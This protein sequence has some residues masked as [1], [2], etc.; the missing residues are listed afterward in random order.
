MCVCLFLGQ[1]HD[2]AQRYRQS[3]NLD[4]ALKYADPS[5]HPRFRAECVLAKARISLLAGTPIPTEELQESLDLFQKMSNA[6]FE[7]FR[8][9]AESALILGKGQSSVDMLK[10]AHT[11]YLKAQHVCGQIQSISYQLQCDGFTMNI[12]AQEKIIETLRK[13][14]ALVVSL[15]KSSTARSQLDKANIET[16]HRF[17]GLVTDQGKM[18]M[19][20]HEGP[21]MLTLNNLTQ[22]LKIRT[23]DDAFEEKDANMAIRDSLMT[24]LLE[25]T[26]HLKRSLLQDLE[27]YQLCRDFVRGRS[28]PRQAGVSQDTGACSARHQPHDHDSY[29]ML[30]SILGQ[31]ISVNNLDTE[32]LQG[33]KDVVI[34]EYVEGKMKYQKGMDELKYTNLLLDELFPKY[35]HPRVMTHSVKFTHELIRLVSGHQ[36]IMFSMKQRSRKLQEEMQS[37]DDGLAATENLLK[38][39]W[40]EMI[41]NGTPDN[42]L[43]CIYDAERVYGKALTTSRQKPSNL[44][45]FKAHGPSGTNHLCFFRK[46]ISAFQLLYKNGDLMVAFGDLM[47]FWDFLARRPLMPLLPTLASCL[48][49]LEVQTVLAAGIY[50]R[51]SLEPTPVLLPASYLAAVNFWDSIFKAKFSTEHHSMYYVIQQYKPGLLWK[52]QFEGRLRKL[53]KIFC[54]KAFRSFNIMGDS[55]TQEAL[56]TGE[57]ERTLILSLVL[58]CNSGLNTILPVDCGSVIREA[59]S[60]I[61][62]SH[63]QNV[64]PRI[65]DALSGIRT[66]STQVQFVII[67]KTLLMKRE[68][69][70]LYRC[71][72]DWRRINGISYHGIM[73]QKF[74]KLDFVGMRNFEPMVTS[75]DHQKFLAGP[76]KY[77]PT[78][79]Q[80]DKVPGVPGDD[81]DGSLQEE[82]IQITEAEILEL[83]AQQ[84]RAEEEKKQQQQI[85]AENSAAEEP[86]SPLHDRIRIDDDM[87]GM[88]KIYF[89]KESALVQ[90]IDEEMEEADADEEREQTEETKKEEAVQPTKGEHLKSL[91][92]EQNVIEFKNY[93]RC[94]DK[95]IL[96]LQTDIQAFETELNR[97]S[98]KA[99]LELLQDRR[100]EMRDLEQKMEK[101]MADIERDCRWGAT[102]DLNRAYDDLKDLF[103]N[104]KTSYKLLKDEQEQVRTP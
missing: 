26:S 6:S 46:F 14:I 21:R 38:I 5:V 94:H 67:L 66:A 104:V 22:K 82:K 101:M 20:L 37:A 75:I 29:K 99:V 33:V 49:I 64:P 4:Q 91:D 89:R 39:F 47:I 19:L 45:I 12:H 42:L 9:M 102:V 48:Q 68:D 30:M 7:D 17:F 35:Y 8:L 103:A 74:E 41:T 43:D 25:T 53:V 59:L 2:V 15:S 78:K 92:H 70:F 72:W 58:L 76:G 85:E 13:N 63:L 23:N 84:R 28:C 50:L 98:P 73:Y 31:I 81:P 86:I 51:H 100:F 40:L 11:W 34:T 18:K 71:H 79:W 55:F 1:G 36:V 32:A 90:G 24:E 77:T 44:G 60:R 65:T 96:P 61:D 62:T 54:G 69:E 95:K 52:M 93:A 3:G 97:D 27:K 88:C 83:Q 10:N 57:C 16:C 56:E 87:C 80:T